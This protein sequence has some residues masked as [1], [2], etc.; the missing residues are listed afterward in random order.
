VKDDTASNSPQGQSRVKSIMG[1]R[2]YGC[3]EVCPLTITVLPGKICALTS[4]DWFL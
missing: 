3:I 1:R 4:S 2:E